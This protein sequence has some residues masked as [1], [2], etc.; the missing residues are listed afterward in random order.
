MDT[1][2]PIENQGEVAKQPWLLHILDVN[3]LNFC[4][5]AM[6]YDAAS[7]RDIVSREVD[8]VRPY[9]ILIAVPNTIDSGGVRGMSI[10]M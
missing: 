7:S 2:L 3:T 6:C 5:F 10:S 4:S 1:T 9:P 8:I